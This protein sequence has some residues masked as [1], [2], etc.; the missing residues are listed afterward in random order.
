MFGPALLLALYTAI[1][2]ADGF[3]A[4]IQIGR[5]LVAGAVSGLILGDFYQGMIIG[6]TLE[7]MWLGV[8][9]I[10][11][12][13]P[14]D[15]LTGTVVGTAVGILTG[16][17]AVA[18]IAIAIPV[19]VAVQQLDIM[20]RT[21]AV[22]FTHRAD[23]AALTGDFDKAARYH[24]MNLPIF[25]LTRAIPVFLAVLIGVEYVEALFGA[26]PAF[27]LDGLRV[28]GNILPALGFGLLLTLL[29]DKRIGIFF[30]MGFVLS[31][32]L[33]IPTMGIAIIGVI[34][35]FLYDRL[36]NQEGR[37]PAAAADEKDAEGRY[38]L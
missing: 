7:L 8:V 34:S 32:Y 3:T 29:M 13:V 26:M 18:G 11:A 27:I 2:A 17:G 5:P 35:A 14:P 12:F 1:A 22:F 6:A 30:L 37:A 15:A 25:M 38:D 20:A 21:F 24:L 33:G 36:S 4:Q 19:A 31:A 28:S 23:K 16:Q 9:A 10:G